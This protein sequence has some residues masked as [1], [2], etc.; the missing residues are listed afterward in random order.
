MLDDARASLLLA[1]PGSD[2]VCPRLAHDGP[3]AP[4]PASTPQQLAYVIYTSGSSGTPKPVGMSHAGAVN[5]AF[6]RLAHDPIGPGDRVLAAISVG[7]DVS[8]G[9]LLL[10]LLHGACVVVAPSLRHLD[11]QDFWALLSAH[12]VTHLNSVPSF[13]EAVLEA[14]PPYQGLKRLMLGGEPLSAALARKLRASMP[15]TQLLNM[16]GP[17][18]TCIDA[19]SYLLPT[20]ELP[21]T[22]P[23]GSPLPNYRAYV[24][25]AQW[26]PAPIGVAGELCIGGASLARGYLGRPAQTAERFVADPFGPP[27]S[28]LYRTGD[29]ARWRPDA[30]LDFLGR[31]DQQVK[32]RGFRVEIGE[33]EAALRSIDRISQAAVLPSTDCGNTRL[34]AYLVG[35]ACPDALITDALASTL[36]E[37]ML[38]SAFVWL[39]ALPLTNNGKLDAK[40]L[41]VPQ[42]A[43]LA[44]HYVAPRSALESSL[45]QVWQQILKRDRVGVH[46]NFFALGG[47]SLMA[48]QLHAACE[49]AA[50]AKMP[51]S[52]VFTHSTIDKM[53]RLLAH[54]DGEIA[55]DILVPIR[56]EGRR[57]ALF[58]IHPQGGT[59]HCYHDLAQRLP[60]DI[61]IYGLQALGLQAGEAPLDSVEAM[62][63]TY[64]ARMRTLQAHG[65]Y[66]IAGYSSGGL[67]AY[68]IARL[69]REQGETPGLLVMIDVPRPDL[70]QMAMPT[71]A[72]VPEDALPMF[73][74]AP[75]DPQPRNLA[76]LIAATRARG[77][78]PADFGLADAE[79]LMA[80][81]LATVQAARSYRPAPSTV[82]T[83]QLRALR[84]DG[85][86]PSDW[87]ELL[88]GTT[89]TLDLD[90]SHT[91]LMEAPFAVRIADFLSPH[92]L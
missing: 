32:I 30:S 27:G 34:I 58:C 89:T 79:R 85:R 73:G 16:Y 28:R 50:A 43:P 36:P 23:I 71:E 68:D 48:I 6:S 91:E 80:V 87:G 63:S 88:D 72:E 22:M 5:L 76:E 33:I 57:T 19:T 24:L 8:I 75:T 78:I 84:S 11:A 29:L 31:N 90:A 35:H 77:L 42:T 13:F 67:I 82:R 41:P 56:P 51:L 54:A 37:H 66:Q 14:G 81:S 47:N 62:A 25:D 10:P 60:P 86:A 26:R 83:V 3:C 59:V 52:A 17:T 1:S 53:A 65:P 92:L 7:F 45:Q 69:L 15:S 9:Q 18:E 21:L 4:C 49:R 39:D 40:A 64:L 38:P 55:N 20:G 46:D 12:A 74:I 61:P 70:D 44:Q 2:L